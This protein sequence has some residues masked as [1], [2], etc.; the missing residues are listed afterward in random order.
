MKIFY[1]SRA[2]FPSEVSHTLSIHNLCLAFAK[3]NIDVLLYGIKSNKG[4]VTSFYGSNSEN[5]SYALVS[6]PSLLKTRVAKWFQLYSILIAIDSIRHIRRFK[7]DII[8]SR[9]TILEM[10]FLPSKIPIYYEMHSY[11]VQ[12]KVRLYN[13]IFKFLLKIKNFEK[14]IVTS[15]EL[16]KSFEIKYKNIQIIKAPLSAEEP[17]T[18][19]DDK[20]E[21][22][23]KSLCG[24]KEYKYHVGY[25]GYLDDSDVR[26]MSTLIDIADANNN[27]FLHV[28][29]GSKKM[30]SVWQKRAESK[31]VNNI[32]F[33]GYK[34]PITIPYY[35]NIFDVVLAPLK[36]RPISRAPTGQNMS[37]LKL[38]QYMAYSKAII[39]SDIPSH[40]DFINNKVNALLVPYDNIGEWGKAI[41]LVLT[42]PDIKSNLENNAFNSYVAD[43]TPKTRIDT[44]L[45][46]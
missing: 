6:I 42:N 33:Y 3:N 12:G 27:F 21:L 16:K 19:K 40:C 1:L 13:T 23:K 44:I 10:M 7:P 2:E 18:L 35:L 11:G 34:S 38:A 37:P 43:Y 25:T 15:D 29:G 32:F 46:N 30:K 28:I 24:Y 22:L 20:L 8:Y 17:I 45:K 39:A 31:G 5:L 41:N 4:A 14:I 36:Y 9:L 26:G